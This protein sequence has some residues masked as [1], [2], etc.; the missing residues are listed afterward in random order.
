[1]RQR[2][3]GRRAAGYTLLEV[4]I[5]SLILA[6]L[7][8]TL[9]E[10]S[11]FM[12]RMTSTGNV[13]TVM[14]I[15]GEKALA[16]IVADLRRTGYLDNIGGKNFPYVFTNGVAEAPFENH[17]HPP[18]DSEADRDDLD[19][20]PNRE[21]VIVAPADADGNGRPD[22]D[23]DGALVWSPDEISYT[24][25]TRSGT[26][27]LE[28]AVNGADSRPVCRFVERLVFDTDE[29]SGFQIPFGSM[30]VRLF[31]RARDSMGALYR[32]SSEVVVKLRNGGT[33]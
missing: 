32:Q 21:V 30:R 10:S 11:N 6:F 7:A 26:N 25:V 12:S 16:K 5:A 33:Q 23:A 27:Y 1:M 4:V 3:R 31:L 22:L 17:S 20:G 13:Q 28:R 9:V 24:V 8:H 19:F 15:E 29:S 14:Q 18:A 2:I